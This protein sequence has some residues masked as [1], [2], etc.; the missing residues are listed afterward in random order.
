MKKTVLSPPSR[1]HK[2]DCQS[3]YLIASASRIETFM[4]KSIDEM[5]VAEL[6]ASVKAGKWS[7]VD[8]DVV[9]ADG[10]SIHYV[11]EDFETGRYVDDVSSVAVIAAKLGLEAYP[12]STVREFLKR[13]LPK[14]WARHEDYTN[15]LNALED[16]EDAEL[17]EVEYHREYGNRR[18]GHLWLVIDG[19]VWH[20][21]DDRVVVKE[22]KK[23]SGRGGGGCHYKLL[24]PASAKIEELWESDYGE[25]ALDTRGFVR[26]G[27]DGKWVKSDVGDSDDTDEDSGNTPFADFF[28]K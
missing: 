27:L 19:H 10:V 11:I 28:K 6:K 24:V 14:T 20:D 22:E 15:A 3:R 21:D 26:E 7:T 1:A 8:Y 9:L 25:D 12:P 4:G 5:C 2:R 13:E 16:V 18:R 23:Y 17:V